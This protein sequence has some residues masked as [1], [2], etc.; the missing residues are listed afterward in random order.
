MQSGFQ[1]RD[2]LHEFGQTT[3]ISR[4]DASTTASSQ[5][6]PRGDSCPAGTWPNPGL[7]G[8]GFLFQPRFRVEVE[9][10]TQ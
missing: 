3:T 9:E 4:I 10:V 2:Q 7:Q 8:G 1:A 6:V 5:Q